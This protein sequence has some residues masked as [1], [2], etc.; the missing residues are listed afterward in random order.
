[1]VGLGVR[2]GGEVMPQAAL[3][4]HKIWRI[5]ASRNTIVSLGSGNLGFTGTACLWN[6]GNSEPNTVADFGKDAQYGVPDIARYGGTLTSQPLANPQFARGCSLEPS[7]AASLLGLRTQAT[8]FPSDGTLRG[9]V[10]A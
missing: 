8:S 7:A 6:F 4:V 9:P 3:N 2:C 1:M 10:P 5:C